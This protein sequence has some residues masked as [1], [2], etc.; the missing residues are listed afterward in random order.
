MKSSFLKLM[1]GL[2]LTVWP[3]I[4]YGQ[5]VFGSIAGT[6]TDP[7]GAAVPGAK[8]SITETGKGVTYNTVS[9]D[10]G[11][12]VQSHLAVGTYDVRVEAPGFEALLRRNVHVD[13]DEVAQ[14]SPQLTL[15]KV[16]E[17]VSVTA[18][19]ALLK[20]Q[21]SDVSDTIEQK[22]V[23]EIPIYDRDVSRVYFLVP[24]IQ[25]G[26]LTASSEQPQDI[27]RPKINGSYWGGI[28]FQLD[29]TDNRESVLGEPV[30]T[31]KPDALSELKISTTSY[32]AEFGQASQAVIVAQTKSGSNQL[33]GGAFDY[34]RDQHGQA[35]DPFTQSQPLPG[36]TDKFI[37]AT[38]RNDFGGSIGG[39]IQKD[40]MF[41]FGDYEGT[42]QK[43]GNSLLLTVPTAAERAGNLSDLGVNIF[44]PC[45][46]GNPNC[47]TAVLDPAS[48]NPTTTRQQFAGNII[49]AG[50]ISSQATALLQ[51]IP[52]PNVPGA[53]GGTAN[54]VANGTGIVNTNSFDTRIDRHQSEKLDMFGRYSL[55]QVSQ[56]APGAFGLEAG[57]PQFPNPNFAGTSSLRNQSLAYGTTYLINNN[58]VSDF[59]FGFF[60]Y[61]VFVNPNGLGTSPAKD[62]GIPGLNLDSYYSSGMPGITINQLGSPTF[63]FGYSLGE[64]QCN[65]PLNEQE[66]EFQWVGNVTHTFGNHSLK[67]GVDVRH[68]Q[69]LRVPSDFHRSGLLSFDAVATSGPAGGGK[70]TGGLGLASFL[71]GD[72]SGT[73]SNSPNATF[74]RYVSNST[75]A[76][77][78]QNRLFSYIQDTWR[79]TPKLTL[80]YGLRWDIY[81]PQYVNAAG[82]GGFIN[83]NTGEVLIAGQNGI[84]LNG[85][86]N[87][88]YKHFAPRLGVAYQLNPKTVVRA[89]YGRSYDVGVFGVSF[90]HNV[91]QNLPVLAS[92][93]IN[94]TQAYAPVFTLAQGPPAVADPSAIL[95]ASPLGP[96]GNHLLPDKFSA[97]VLP[98]SSDNT[99]RL[100]TMDAW[101]LTIERQIT[102]TLVVS[103][104]YVGNKEEHV[105]PGGSSYNTNQPQL[106]AGGPPTNT[107]LRRFYFQKFGWTQS[108]NGYTDDAT[109][110]YSGLQ[111]RGEK[112]F[113]NGLS[114]QANFTW[115]SA[116]DFA[117]DYFFWDRSI[118][119]GRESGVRRE[120]FNLNHVYELPF[121]RGKSF[122]NNPSGPVDY[123]I[124][125]WQLSGVWLWGSGMPFTPSY[126]ECGSDIDTGPCRANL[127]GNAN[128]SNPGTGNSIGGVLQNPWFAVATPGTSGTG[129]T[130]TTTATNVLNQNGCTRG[131]W[132]RPGVGTFGNVGLN[133]FY[134]PRF[135]NADAALSKRFKITERVNTQFRAELFNV[136]NDVNLGQPNG[137]VD[138][139]T[140][141]QITALAT[142]NLA[143]M[144]RWQFGLRVDF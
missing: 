128:I 32:D 134:G 61:R 41:F 39:P 143:Q 93:S 82:A 45:P 117:N 63:A 48:T 79:F 76:A 130:A 4:S 112:R 105:T 8:V 68:A 60:R 62:A 92:Q 114:F 13:V 51:F 106:N 25:P 99:M 108:L 141:G 133:S 124:G 74:Y 11:N 29:G 121:G 111:L 64:N 44:D 97:K 126:N 55:L 80:N 54:Y 138:S 18:E 9:N 86:V 109:V 72:V 15:G 84:G 104:A 131:P 73:S 100:P 19:E 132:Q 113:S 30:I 47:G 50:R 89:G 96:T 102:S 42:R 22:T 125:G 3:A 49:P 28:S 71:L 129:C 10:S 123:L 88:N 23:A 38:L 40:K 14:V 70:T 87:T 59:R 24:G 34:R 144:R 116:F 12:Y 43:L 7:S 101:N 58:W 31:P 66:N 122:F 119:Y 36:T 5:A 140:A 37:P 120:V 75:D 21:K 69:N 35:R 118:D 53:A 95:A 136:F 27:Y 127:V 115:A 91:T 135:F 98:L 137:N 77:E 83:I 16:S 20:T 90:G 142:G 1:M 56:S 67:F 94:P 6:V 52:L 26:G 103:A 46:A 57:G 107:N 2:I 139:K 81:F 65:C 85:N 78:R 110:K 17:T 33:H